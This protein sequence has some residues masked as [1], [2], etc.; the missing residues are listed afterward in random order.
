MKLRK[1]GKAKVNVLT[2]KENMDSVLGGA[3]DLVTKLME[4]AMTCCLFCFG[5][6]AVKFDLPAFE[7]VPT[8]EKDQGNIYI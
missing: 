5:C 6:L 4:R 7:R 2:S 1:I 3:E 8:V